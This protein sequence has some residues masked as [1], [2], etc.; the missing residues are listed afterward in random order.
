MRWKN[1]CRQGTWDKRG[2]DS[3]RKRPGAG[4][5]ASLPC[6]R[7]PFVLGCGF[8]T[9]PSA[10]QRP[11]KGPWPAEG[12][13]RRG[14]TVGGGRGAAFAE[15]CRALAGPPAGSLPSKPAAGDSRPSGRHFIQNRGRAAPSPGAAKGIFRM[16]S[17]GFLLPGGIGA[18]RPLLGRLPVRG[19]TLA[20][21][22]AALGE[23]GRRRAVG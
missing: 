9:K 18:L 21:G 16:G 19:G 14:N 15:S 5:R 17:G 3:K 8:R 2:G 23:F 22:P 11:L 4:R 13:K 20:R 10:G 6:A 12:R 7:P 1:C